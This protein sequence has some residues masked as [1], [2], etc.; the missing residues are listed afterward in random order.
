MLVEGFLPFSIEGIVKI[1]ESERI[2]VYLLD[3]DSSSILGRVVSQSGKPVLVHYKDGGKFEVLEDSIDVDRVCSEEGG[4]KVSGHEF[5]YVFRRGVFSKHLYLVR[6]GY[7]CDV[8]YIFRNV[9]SVYSY[10]DSYEFISVYSSGRE[11]VAVI[12]TCCGSSVFVVRRRPLDILRGFASIGF[13]YRDSLRVFTSSGRVIEVPWATWR[14]RFRLKLLGVDEENVFFLIGNTLYSYEADGG[15][16]EP[17]SKC[18]EHYL[19]RHYNGAISIVCEG[20]VYGKFI[21]SSSLR[22]LEFLEEFISRYGEIYAVYP[23]SIIVDSSNLSL[24]KLHSSISRVVLDTKSRRV[25][26]ISNVSGNVSYGKNNYIGKFVENLWPNRGGISVLYSINRRGLG[27]EYLV[28]GRALQGY[29]EVG[30]GGPLEYSEELV[31]E[32]DGHIYKPISIR[33]SE[34][35]TPFMSLVYPIFSSRSNYRVC[36]RDKSHCIQIRPLSRTDYIVYARTTSLRAGLRGIYLE[37]QVAINRDGVVSADILEC[38][39]S[40]KFENNGLLKIVATVVL[41]LDK[42]KGE[43]KC[44]ALLNYYDNSIAKIPVISSREA[45]KLFGEYSSRRLFIDDNYSGVFIDLESSGLIYIEHNDVGHIVE[46]KLTIRI[47]SSGRVS[48]YSKNGVEELGFEGLEVPR[49]SYIVDSD[50]LRVK[51]SGECLLLCCNGVQLKGSNE[52]TIALNK[53]LCNECSLLVTN[54]GVSKVLYIPIIKLMISG[55]VRNSYLLSRLLLSS[56]S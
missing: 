39:G 5:I 49:A 40:I 8:S 36:L 20:Q 9:R 48:I 56:L 44:S 52:L 26:V 17:V 55:A 41:G 12:D 30:V 38:D 42:L 34:I 37:K 23:F 31:L 51:C 1:G 16:L 47:P 29:L 21:P 24:V 22:Y 10:R 13:L 6:R 4:E 32:V 2:D 28:D 3:V 14:S 18:S 46:G 53:V 43:F 19:L 50:S 25:F 27:L 54:K 11:Y 7:P 35:D 15:F 33:Y 45:M